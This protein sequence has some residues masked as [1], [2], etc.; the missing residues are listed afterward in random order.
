[1]TIQCKREKEVLSILQVYMQ[2]NVHIHHENYGSIMME[3]PG[4]WQQY[5]SYPQTLWLFSCV[6]VIPLGQ[7]REDAFLMCP[8]Y[9]HKMYS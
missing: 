4:L 2:G 3:V 6:H 5:K 7:K 9:K 8:F 1:V